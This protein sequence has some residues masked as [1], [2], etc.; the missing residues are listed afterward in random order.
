MLSRE[1]IEEAMAD[2]VKRG[3]VT[4]DDAQRLVTEI[5]DRGRKQTNDVLGD[6]EQLLGRSRDEIEGR[7]RPARK[8]GTTAARRARKQVEDATSKARKQAV[9]QANPV[10][11]QADRARR[12]AGIGRSFPITGYDDLTVPR[13]RAG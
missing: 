2:A 9:K 6:L 13:C 7:A 8:R 5:V 4:T 3:R 11:A 12:A 10:L 1:R